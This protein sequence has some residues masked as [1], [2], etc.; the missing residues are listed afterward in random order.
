MAS[1]KAIMMKVQEN[2]V[3]R[4]IHPFRMGIIGQ[5]MAGKSLLIKE[6]IR[7]RR[8][9]FT[10]EYSAIYYCLPESPFNSGFEKFTHELKTICPEIQ[11][12]ENLPS[13][14]LLRASELPKLF[15]LD[16]LMEEIFKSNFMPEFF[17]RGS[18]HFSNSIMFTRDQAHNIICLAVVLNKLISLPTSPH[19]FFYNWD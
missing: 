3:N 2:Y 18:H 10:T 5:T 13:L 12:L 6:I 8:Q 11:I 14:D 17:T 9:L 4:F 19:F 1:N 16:D 15:I 7:F